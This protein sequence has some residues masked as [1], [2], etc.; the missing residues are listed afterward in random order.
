VSLPP[1]DALPRIPRDAQGP[2]FREPWEAQAF[3][4]AVRLHQAGVFTWTQWASALAD[5]IRGAK[6]RGDADLGDTYYRHWLAAL[7][8]L[9]AEAKLVSPDETRAR[10]AEIER[11][12]RRDH[13]RRHDHDH[14]HS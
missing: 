9:L 1:L 7:E 6:V 13:A 2:V 5:E 4:L 11:A 12:M 14:H 3:A 8:R 10:G